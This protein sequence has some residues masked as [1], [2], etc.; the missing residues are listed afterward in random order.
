MTGE[1]V[2]LF[3]I[4]MNVRFCDEQKRKSPFFNQKGAFL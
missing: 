3:Q 2:K 4:D 1:I